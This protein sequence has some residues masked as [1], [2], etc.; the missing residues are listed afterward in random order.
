MLNNGTRESNFKLSINTEVTQ[1]LF[2]ENNKAYG[3]RSGL[4]GRM[5]TLKAKKEVIL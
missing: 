2:D 5:I 3:V 1:V 4:N